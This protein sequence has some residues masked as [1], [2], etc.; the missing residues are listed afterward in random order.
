MTFRLRDDSVWKL[1]ILMMMG[2][3]AVIVLLL[4][5]VPSLPLSLFLSSMPAFVV[6]A[7]AFN[8]IEYWLWK[9]WINRNG[10]QLTF[11]CGIAGIHAPFRRIACEETKLTCRMDIQSQNQVLEFW[12]LSVALPTEG[13]VY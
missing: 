9:G 6:L 5:F 4:L 3:T 2:C 10:Q 11:D 7:V 12:N 13:S 8:A 1:A